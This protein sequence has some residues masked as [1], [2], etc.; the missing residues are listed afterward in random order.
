ME[1]A[2]RTER[3][4][5]DV[6]IPLFSSLRRDENRRGGKIPPGYRWRDYSAMAVVMV[7]VAFGLQHLY[8]VRGPLV[9]RWPPVRS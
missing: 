9:C 1:P 6:V 2:R 3:A 4:S 8:K 5:A 7:G